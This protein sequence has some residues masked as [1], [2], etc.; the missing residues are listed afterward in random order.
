MAAL[1]EAVSA[2]KSQ[3]EFRVGQKTHLPGHQNVAARRAIARPP[4]SA[5]A[6]RARSRLPGAL[7]WSLKFAENLSFRSASVVSH[8]HTSSA[9]GMAGEACKG[10]TLAP[11][12]LEA[13][14]VPRSAEK[15]G[16]SGTS[17]SRND[18]LLVTYCGDQ[19]CAS[20]S[21]YKS[22]VLLHYT[23]VNII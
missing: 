3:C 12:W 23:H 14:R 7:L 15:S 16:T 4:K 2:G 13:Q 22:Q 5:R 17:G 19:Y 9:R 10:Y 11:R 18:A 8:T 21:K 6:E 20:I 1:E